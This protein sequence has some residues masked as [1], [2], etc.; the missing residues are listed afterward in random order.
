MRDI[1]L[2]NSTKMFS[3]NS[4]GHAV[5]PTEFERVTFNEEQAA[6]RVR[7]AIDGSMSVEEE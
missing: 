2:V 4:Q 6:A 1:V 7:L 3:I 5:S